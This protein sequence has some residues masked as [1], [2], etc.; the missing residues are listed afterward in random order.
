MFCNVID[1]GP[2]MF[3]VLLSRGGGNVMEWTDNVFSAQ[4]TADKVVKGG[5]YSK[6]DW[7]TRC[8]Y[9]YNMLPGS[10][11]NEVGFRC[12]KPPNR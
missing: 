6:P 1:T 11:S 2:F 10:T 9:R 5:S 8:A 3:L 12:C 7:A 4:D